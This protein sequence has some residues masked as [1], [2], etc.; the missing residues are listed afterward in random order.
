MRR[1]WRGSRR[2]CAASGRR[3]GR[4]CSGAGAAHGA[5]NPRISWA[6]SSGDVELRAVTDAVEL[7]PVGVGQP[8]GAKARGG[9][10]P[11]Q[12]PVRGAPHDPHRA[13]D[14]LRVERPA[15]APRVLDQRRRP[16]AAPPRRASDGRAAR[17]G[18]ARSWSSTSSV[19]RR[20]PSDD[21]RIASACGAA[22]CTSSYSAAW[23]ASTLSEDVVTRA[24]SRRPGR[25]RRPSAPG[26]AR[27]A[28]ARRSRRASCPRGARV[29]KPASSIARSTA[30]A[31]TALATSPSIGGPPACP[32]SV[33]ASTSCRRS[34]AG[35]TSSQL[36]Q[37][38]NEAVQAHER[39]P[40]AAAVRWGEG[41]RIQAPDATRGR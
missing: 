14:P 7:H 2:S 17:P 9:R 36:R 5:V 41:R 25:A 27:R 22:A 16:R 33:G 34:S 10:R 15:G 40:G 32:A 6:V 18:C 29:S 11:R 35:S 30:S 20:R 23:R 39:R 38:S 19:A 28:A 21:A 1:R 24:P 3:C 13:G 4:S 8:L 37:V 26:R 12:E 31:S